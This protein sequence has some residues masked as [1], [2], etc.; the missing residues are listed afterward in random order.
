M[1]LLN[2]FTDGIETMAKIEFESWS[3][4]TDDII[5]EIAEY[6]SLMSVQ[7][8]I[9]ELCIARANN[10]GHASFKPGELAMLA[11]GDDTRADKQA[12]T[13]GIAKLGT[14][15]R[16]DVKRS[17]PLCIILNHDLV[18]RYGKGSRKHMCWEPSHAEYR[19]QCWEPGAEGFTGYADDTYDAYEPDDYGREKETHVTQDPSTSAPRSWRKT[20]E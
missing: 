9:W 17:T 16:V 20:W 18:M 13:R 4:V 14:M 2:Q 19:D 12:V 11:C 10:F 5:S 15:R 6:R 3:A 7:W 8:R 1:P